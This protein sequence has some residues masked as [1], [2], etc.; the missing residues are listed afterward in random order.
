MRRAAGGSAQQTSEE[1]IGLSN[2]ARLMRL[3]NEQGVPTP[4]V[5]FELQDSDELGAGFVMAWLSGETRGARIARQEKFAN[6]RRSLAYECGKVL[7][8]IHAIDIEHN[9]LEKLLPER[10]P[11]SFVRDTWARYRAMQ[12]PQPMLD[13]TAQWLLQN[14]PRTSRRALVHNDFR[15]GNLMVDE[16][17]IVAVLDWE[18]AHIGDPYRDLGWVCTGSWRFGE[19]SPVGGFGQREELYAGYEAGGGATVDPDEARFWE[20]FGSFWWG[21]GCLMMAQQY[22]DGPDPSVERPAIGRRSSE[23]QMDCANM[24]IPGT[25]DQIG[26]FDSSDDQLPSEAELLESVA[27]FLRDDVMAETVGRVNFLARVAANSIDIALREQQLGPDL[28]AAELARLR[29]LFDSQNDLSELRWRLVNALRD[30][31]IELT[32]TDLCRHLRQSTYEN[33][34]IDQPHYPAFANASRFD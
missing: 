27:G 22:R 14:L 19:P 23:C 10:S 26:T 21:V 33:L 8:K 1:N 4:K 2:E 28:R 3:A 29:A 15:N 34:A 24:L 9:A 6:L 5:L 31:S 13:Y 11:E 30:G 12:T 25:V 16:E 18:V 17:K 7:A 20:V 32:D